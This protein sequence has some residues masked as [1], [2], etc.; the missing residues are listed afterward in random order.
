MK[1]LFLVLIIILLCSIFVSAD[2]FRDIVIDVSTPYGEP[3]G[4]VFISMYQQYND[5][6]N[7]N[8]VTDSEG[9]IT[10]ENVDARAW[11]PVTPGDEVPK[12]GRAHV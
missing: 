12:I 3:V 5:Y 1:R 8:G 10:F 2:P 11:M 9:M 6:Y 4:N 7:Y